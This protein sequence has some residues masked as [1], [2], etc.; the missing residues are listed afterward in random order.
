MNSKGKIK[1]LH[2]QTEINL[3]CGVTRT[4]S[5]IIKNT[6]QDFEHH[7]IALDGDGLKRFTDFGF[8]PLFLNNKR[9]SLIKTVKIFL[10]LARFCKNN[11]IQVIH[12][13]HRY[14]DTISWLIQLFYPIKTVTSV[15]SKVL[16][17]KFFS[18]KADILIACSNSI[19][20]HLINNFKVSQNKILV[21]H[22]STEPAE[23]NILRSRK[24]ILT[25]LNIPNGRIIIGFIGRINFNEKGVD[26]LLEAFKQLSQNRK[27]LFLVLIGNGQN[28]SDVRV[29]F[30]RYNLNALL[31]P[32]KTDI[33]E[34]L[35]VIDIFILASRVDPFPLT[36]LEAGL[37]KVP[38]IG[39]DVDGISE[40]I[41]HEKDGLL[42]ESDDIDDLIMQIIRFLD[43]DKLRYGLSQNLY[44]KIISSFTTDRIIP[45]YVKLYSD[46]IKSD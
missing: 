35:N 20:E 18:Y 31:L 26:I 42:F 41:E 3:T 13:H 19:K 7:L 24:E 43:D 17:K 39:S 12:S 36:M 22:N 33:N 9:N 5:Q 46:V 45:Q 10:T 6:S 14:F 21:I 11:S 23:L 40:L 30:K 1:I 29:Y 15:H 25:E 8:N 28:E 34:Y 37:M 32:P 2:L 38:F 16:G 27:N 4:I 44:Q